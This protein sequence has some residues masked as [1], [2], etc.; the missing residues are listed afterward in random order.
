MTV[1]PVPILGPGGFKID[2][3]GFFLEGLAILPGNTSFGKQDISVDT[4]RSTLVN[5][6]L[7]T[8]TLCN[9]ENGIIN[10][11]GGLGDQGLTQG[12]GMLYH[13]I[14]GPADLVTYIGSFLTVQYN[15][16]V[17]AATTPNSNIYA[18][19]W[20]GPPTSQFN[21]TDQQL[22]LYG[23]VNA[24]QLPVVSAPN[25][26]TNGTNPGPSPNGTNP[27]TTGSNN[28]HAT[29]T[30]H[31]AA[32]VGGVLGGLAMLAI[33][34]LLILYTT[35]R[36]RR[37]AQMQETELNLDI[38]AFYMTENESTRPQVPSTIH[39]SVLTLSTMTLNANTGSG[40]E[41][42][43]KHQR[44]SRFTD[45]I[46]EDPP[47]TNSSPLEQIPI[48]D[49][50]QLLQARIQEARLE[51]GSAPPAYEVSGSQ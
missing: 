19:S 11:G 15:T 4:L 2:Q 16:I 45:P 41:Y 33:I 10:V 17:T 12:L 24:A 5:I 48:T 27:N 9:A 3:A 7:T 51:Q 14:S 37:N 49:I 21:P 34:A 23:L 43:G 38:D 20:I 26:T 13:T 22:A 35:R 6:T 50:L 25:A 42:G 47:S 30:S 39:Q 28:N 1:L 18:G 29:Q 31:I 46:S 8:N 40:T 32:I 36:R 44:E